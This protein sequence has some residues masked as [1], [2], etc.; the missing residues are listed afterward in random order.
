[1]KISPHFFAIAISCLAV[2]VGYYFYNEDEIHRKV[3]EQG[4][5]VTEA[6]VTLSEHNKRI[7][8]TREEVE[9][10]EGRISVLE[11]ELQQVESALEGTTEK[12]GEQQKELEGLARADELRAEELAKL[13]ADVA[14]LRELQVKQQNEYTHLVRRLAE[15]IDDL[16]EKTQIIPKIKLE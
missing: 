1:M 11:K 12:L 14:A 5:R 16:E 9:T 13:Q 3:E 15:R 6:E 10:N 8:S 4:Q 2:G 7:E